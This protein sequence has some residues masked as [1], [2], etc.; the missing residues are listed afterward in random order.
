MNRTMI[1]F[2]CMGTLSATLEMV[3]A[4][5]FDLRFGCCALSAQNSKHLHPNSFHTH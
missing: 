1:S 3:R 5:C 2:V 4:L